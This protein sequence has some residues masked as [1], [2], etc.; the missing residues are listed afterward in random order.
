[1]WNPLEY[2]GWGHSPYNKANLVPIADMGGELGVPL[3][4][5]GDPEFT[6]NDQVEKNRILLMGILQQSVTG[7]DTD[8]GNFGAYHSFLV[9]EKGGDKEP[10]TLKEM[11]GHN[12]IREVS[13][14]V[15]TSEDVLYLKICRKFQ[16]DDQILL[17][18]FERRVGRGSEWSLKVCE[19]PESSRFQKA[20]HDKERGKSVQVSVPIIF[21]NRPSPEIDCDVSYRKIYVLPHGKIAGVTLKN[22]LIKLFNHEEVAFDDY[23]NEIYCLSKK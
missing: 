5:F 11:K 23:P 2:L 1:M 13:Y 3:V 14:P 6:P 8:Y 20:Y 4:K 16:E 19:A 7:R 15:E 18:L 22:M 12:L 9:Y 17:G 10:I 21:E